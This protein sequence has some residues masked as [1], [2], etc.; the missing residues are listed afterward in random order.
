VKNLST[1]NRGGWTQPPYH[2]KGKIRRNL[3][4]SPED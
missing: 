2:R 3:K 4:K 1:Q